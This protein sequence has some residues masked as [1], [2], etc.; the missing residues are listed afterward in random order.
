MPD[1]R[2]ITNGIRRCEFADY[3]AAKTRQ[4]ID[5]TMASGADIFS[6]LQ[7]CSIL[8]WFFYTEGRW[9]EVWIFCGF[10]VRVAIPLRLN[11]TKT[12]SNHGSA[13][14]GAY[15]LP[16]K[17][18]KDL[19]MRRRTW[20][21]SIIFD[22]LVSVGGWI[23]AIEKDRIITELPLRR[24]DYEQGVRCTAKPRRTYLLL[25]FL[26]Q[27]Q[28]PDNPQT[29]QSPD[30]YT[31]HPEEYTDSFNLFLKSVMLFG[32]ITDINTDYN[33]SFPESPKRTD[34]PY[35][36]PGFAFLDKLAAEDFLASLPPQYQ[37]IIVRDPFNED[38]LEFRIDNDQYMVHMVP[39]G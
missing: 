25:C 21:M 33:L 11:H 16:P 10:Q 30:F 5:K 32:L 18:Q 14:P 34:D 24:V 35:D 13:S 2:V 1:T 6:V 37:H 8:S 3:H 15:I 26:L 7:A 20:W 38:N 23:H 28:M 39:H 4:Y 29:M 36:R 9:V 27:R 22:R 12:Y 17:N 19:E 31:I